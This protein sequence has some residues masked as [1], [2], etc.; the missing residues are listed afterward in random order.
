MRWIIAALAL[1]V[2]AWIVPGIRVEGVAWVV[3][4]VMAIV[5]GLINAVVR[6]VLKLL[7]CPLILLTLG[8][9]VLVVNGITLLLASWIAVNWFDV[10]FY[11]DSFWAAV[12]GAAIVSVVTVILSVFVR[13]DED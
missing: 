3:Y 6:P 13:E 8:V 12:L 7:T 4:A 2:A 11:V 1:F 10:Y 9:F 5:L